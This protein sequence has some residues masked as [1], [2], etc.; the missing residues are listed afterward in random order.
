MAWVEQLDPA[1][2]E[3][4]GGGAELLGADDGQ[5]ADDP[6]QRGRLAVGEAQHAGPAARLGERGEDRAQT[7]GLVVGVGAHGEHA[8][9]PPAA[10]GWPADGRRG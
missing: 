1:D 10:R 4:L 5:V 9:D 2:A 7:E 3:H 6:V 8:F